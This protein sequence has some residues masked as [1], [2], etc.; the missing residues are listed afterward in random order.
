MLSEYAWLELVKQNAGAVGEMT[1]LSIASVL[2]PESRRRS[3]AVAVEV[4]VEVWTGVNC[5]S[6]A[7]LARSIR[8]ARLLTV[9]PSSLFP[10]KSSK[11]AEV[12]IGELLPALMHLTRH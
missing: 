8:L 11:M 7:G 3:R 5:I 1:R 10:S 9:A 12:P 4:E 6:L 2:A